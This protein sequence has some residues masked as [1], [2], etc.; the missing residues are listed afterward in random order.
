MMVGSG[1]LTNDFSSITKDCL[2]ILRASSSNK[3]LTYLIADFDYCFVNLAFLCDESFYSSL[4]II[5]EN[6]SFF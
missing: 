5:S 1:N 2:P 6:S 4:E 3:F